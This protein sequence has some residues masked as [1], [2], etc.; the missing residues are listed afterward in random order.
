MEGLFF[1]FFFKFC[2]DG[3]AG[4]VVPQNRWGACDSGHENTFS[5][6]RRNGSTFRYQSF[7]SVTA[8]SPPPTHSTQQ[9]SMAEVTWVSPSQEKAGHAKAIPHKAS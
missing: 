2:L 8:T 4:L 3:K 6:A 9:F 5:G 7:Q 1:F